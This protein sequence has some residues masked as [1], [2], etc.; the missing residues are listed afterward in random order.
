[1]HTFPVPFWALKVNSA[2]FPLEER[3]YSELLVTQILHHE[4]FSSGSGLPS[5]SPGL[6]YGGYPCV[7]LNS[8]FSQ[9]F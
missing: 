6:V 7:F 2:R 9:S 5:S 4:E 8:L 3:V 1:M